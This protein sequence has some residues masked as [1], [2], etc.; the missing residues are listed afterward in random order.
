M[1]DQ[2]SKSG[3]DRAK[4]STTPAGTDKDGRRFT[5]DGP[6][7]RGYRGRSPADTPPGSVPG[8][9]YGAGG[10]YKQGDLGGAG[11]E[12]ETSGSSLA[13]H[14]SGEWSAN[15]DRDSADEE[16]E[17]LWRDAFGSYGFSRSDEARESGMSGYGAQGFGAGEQRGSQW[18]GGPRGG[19]GGGMPGSAR[20]AADD[21]QGRGMP[22]GERGQRRRGKT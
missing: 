12:G 21:A 8:G 17:E 16:E 20:S 9:S 2:S 15:G 19:Y 14:E 7:E 11:A 4:Q 13:D 3:Q 18:G 22:W 1:K 6:G 10:G 5:G